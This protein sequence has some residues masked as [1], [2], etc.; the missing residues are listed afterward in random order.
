MSNRLASVERSL[1]SS[2]GRISY[3]LRNSAAFGKDTVFAFAKPVSARAQ[4]PWPRVYHPA[5]DSAWAGHLAVMINWK[6]KSGDSV[7]VVLKQ[8]GDP[9][10]SAFQTGR[11]LSKDELYDLFEQTGLVERPVKKDPEKTIEEMLLRY[12]PLLVLK[13][14]VRPI[15]GGFVVVGIKGSGERDAT[16]VEII[17][18]LTGKGRRVSL[19]RVL[20]GSKALHVVH[21]PVDARLASSESNQG[22]SYDTYPTQGFSAQSMNQ[23]FDLRY[24]VQLVRQM[25]G[26]SCWAAGCAMLVGWR[27]Q[28][29]VDP[30]SIAAAVGY[31]AQYKSGLH[32]ED[33]KIFKIWGL[34]HDAPQTYTIEGFRML[35]EDYGPL[36]VASAEPGPHIRVVTG[37]HGDG[38]QENTYVLINDP[39]EKGMKTFRPSNNGSKY[40]E[41]YTAFVKKQSTLGRQEMHLNA[42]IYVAHLPELPGWLK[43]MR[44]KGLSAYIDQPSALAVPSYERSGWR[45]D[46][47]YG[48]ISRTAS[49]D[50][51]APTSPATPLVTCAK[52]NH[53]KDELKINSTLA[54]GS[55]GDDVKKVQEW[56]NLWR[57]ASP[58]WSMNVSVDG[59]FGPESD[60]A[61]QAF[62]KMMGHKED[63]IVDN[64]IFEMLTNPLRWAFT[65]IDHTTDIREL[66][67]ACATEHVKSVAVELAYGGASNLGPWV[68]A[69]MLGRD[70]EKF[71]WCM[72]FVQTI[73]DLAFSTVGK[74]YS[75]LMPVSGSCDAIGE[76]GLKDGV[77]IRNSDLPAK[78][79][80]VKPGDLFL[81]VKTS[82]DWTHT[83]IVTEVKENSILTIEG[84]T[85]DEGSRN[86]YEVCS[87]SRDFTKQNFDIF[88][89]NI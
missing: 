84:N 66:I 55:N 51:V 88:K 16:R 36:W 14:N 64:I 48:N 38:T 49:F 11:S 81:S 74:N 63:G 24:D 40:T 86:G 2:K 62:Q 20:N 6:N 1:Y 27:D 7:N 68:R 15:S 77:L 39:W 85:N 17:D 12:G 47:E 80:E 21:W 26:M 89:L 23:S 83:G 82:R 54:K 67:V 25:T 73:L 37:M 41:K 56:L 10:L 33:A 58:D 52:R 76:R 45:I 18:T 75:T 87:R 29:S 60:N 46:P 31:W 13:N 32:P 61:V 70:G 57:Y 35:L 69:Y 22:L 30:S 53:Y 9:A 34:V 44:T 28:M 8:L 79:N 4:K 19:K 5:K 71:Y 43:K 72:G 65:K 59:D 78:I 50:P 3:P 42:P